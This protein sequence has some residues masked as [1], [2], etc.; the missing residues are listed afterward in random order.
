M[1]T[2]NRPIGGQ[3][4][5]LGAIFGAPLQFWGGEPSPCDLPKR[6]GALLL[7][8]DGT[9]VETERDGHRVAFNKAFEETSNSTR[10]REFECSR[11]A[12]GGDV[13]KPRQVVGLRKGFRFQG[14]TPQASHVEGLNF[15]R[16]GGGYENGGSCQATCVVVPHERSQLNSFPELAPLFVCFVFFWVP[17]C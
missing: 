10:P 12:R 2:S 9:L 4:F 6:E 11:R 1:P 13:P 7:D 3:G 15:N 5:L 16:G 8:C 17:L 14:K